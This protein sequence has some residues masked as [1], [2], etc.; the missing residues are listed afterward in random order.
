MKRCFKCL[1]EKPLSEF[2]PHPQMGDGHLNKCKECTKKDAT[3]TRAAR[4]EHYRAYDRARG[5]RQGAEYLREYR[6]KNPLKNRAHQLVSKAV[7]SGKILPMP[8][9][10]CGDDAEA[11]HPDYNQPLDVI[12]LCPAHHKQVHAMTR[13]ILKAA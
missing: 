4:I 9:I 11:H 10:V 13:K 1:A 2:Y 5:N 3:N 7:K 6:R 8:C 12:W